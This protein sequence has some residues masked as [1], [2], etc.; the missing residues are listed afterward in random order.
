MLMTVDEAHSGERTVRRQVSA[1]N[2]S[3]YECF[4]NEWIWMNQNFSSDQQ[5]WETLTKLLKVSSGFDLSSLFPKKNLHAIFPFN[6][7]ADKFQVLPKV[8]SVNFGRGGLSFR[9]YGLYVSLC[10][11]LLLLLG[12]VIE[13][14]FQFLETSATFF[15]GSFWWLHGYPPVPL[16]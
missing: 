7:V 16:N 9:N 10:T 8:F 12:I 6:Y 2:L 5:G 14:Q 1:S 15:S 4:S 3:L 11:S 13:S